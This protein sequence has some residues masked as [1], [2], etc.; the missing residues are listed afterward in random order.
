[1]RHRRSLVLACAAP[2]LVVAAAG[3]QVRGSREREPVRGWEL[4]GLDISPNGGWR[5]RARAVA[6]ARARLLAQ[7]NFSA[8][9]AAPA[10]PAA[11][12]VVTGSIRVPVI[13]FR[14]TDSPPGQYARDTAQYNA[15][16]FAAT[17]PGGR[18]YT[19]RTYYEQVS[20][21]S[22]TILGSAVGW[23]GLA[24]AESTY[25]GAPGSCPG[26]P[27]GTNNCNGLFGGAFSLMQA[28]LVE[29]VQKADAEIDFGQFDNDGPDG[30][31]N[32]GDDDG[33]VDAVFFLHP[34]MDGAC[35][36]PSNNHLWSHR[37]SI[38][39]QTAD[40]A[41]NGGK[42]LVEDYI[43]Q[44][45]L[46]SPSGSVCGDS[47]I[48]PIGTAAHE[49]G[50]LLALPDLYDVQGATEGVG[51]YSIM[52][53]GNYTTSPSPAR[54][55]AW[56]LQQLGWT[57]VV[58]LTA[59]GT[60][61]LGPVPTADTVFLVDVQGSN[62]RSEYF[63]IENRQAV[64]SDSA[65]IRFHCS[66]SGDPP[67]CGGGLL[68]WHIDD[69]KACLI[70]VC[71]NNVNGGSIHGV[72]LEE[73]DGLR[74][75][76]GENVANRGDAGDPYPGTS[77]DTAFSFATNPAAIKNVDSSFVGFAI[78]AIAQTVP[79]GEMTFQLRF[80]GLTVVQASDTTAEIQVDGITQHVF[81]DLV[82]NGS[83]HIIAVA[84]TQVT[85]DSRSRFVF[86]SWSDGGAISHA[87][88][89]T[90]AGAT[91]T[92]T[93]TGEH[94]LTV[95]TLGSGS[96]TYNPVADSS[97]IL[98]PQGT[99]VTLTA[100]PAPSFAFGGWFGDTTA[101]G[102]VLVLPMGRPFTLVARFDPVLTIASG[103]PLPGGIMGK[104][105]ADTLRA[106][107]GTGTYT[108][109]LVGSLP[110]GLGL[111][112]TGLIT[113]TPRQVGTWAF[114]LRATSG[115]QQ[116]VQPLSITITAP[117]LSMDAVV[118]QLLTGSSTL[119]ADDV[120]Y[121]DL[122]G[123]QSGLFDVGDFLAWVQTTGATPVPPLAAA[124][125]REPRP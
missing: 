90:V 41:H 53:S 107:G 92:A 93:L 24:G 77:G 30:L 42:I 43:L 28:G 58:P 45:G 78:D 49:F 121:L 32:S 76:W 95:T 50:H 120:H 37:S 20:N 12:T 34:S 68:V 64:E 83:S 82:A 3:A 47:A 25:A 125:V 80:G 118:A 56:S 73:A 122:L 39:V 97:G 103:D 7:R 62:P 115:A 91:Y 65:M 123:N 5:V 79:N 16:L 52:G 124:R 85:A 2:W 114:S 59:S 117:Q 38:F 29:A 40:S 100:T 119:S 88:T 112:V 86:Q 111:G 66:V 116:V 17:P 104:A 69:T 9:N 1:V 10:G 4:P 26:N 94:R 31:P 113:G 99:P 63:L 46:G 87:V 61:T 8:L 36:G 51:E 75:L 84:D 55:D 110:P 71:G 105:Y 81:R 33:V 19:L 14:Y 11:A 89:G 106:S 108:W 70:T 60:Y 109:Q 35:V 44:S 48:M 22:F 21:G 18:P 96:V 6:A 98:I 15:V 13:L 101:A 72:R 74:Q 67:G 27:F 54:F 102:A 57:N 23:V